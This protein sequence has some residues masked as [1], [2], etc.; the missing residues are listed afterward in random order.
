[1]DANPFQNQGG[2]PA[3]TSSLSAATAQATVHTQTAQTVAQPQPAVITDSERI[4]VLER[5]VAELDIRLKRR[6]GDYA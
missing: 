2:A 6:L 4:A 3:Q 1:M 5:K